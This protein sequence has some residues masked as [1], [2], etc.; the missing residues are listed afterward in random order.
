MHDDYTALFAYNR[1]ADDRVLRSCRRLAPG[2]YTLELGDG[3]RSVRATVVHLAG[4]TDAW[5]RRIRGETVA[6][7]PTEEELPTLDASA[8]LLDEAHDACDR[9]VPE[10]SPG[11]LAATWTYR[12]LQG[13]ARSLPFWAVLRHLVNHGSYHRG[14]I[15]SKLRRLG[16]EPESTDL[17]LWAI[18]SSGR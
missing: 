4:A 1:W 12:N 17:V 16:V 14:Q 15:A 18:E 3:L 2:Q 8:R 13:R 10:L 6:M 7:L 9:L 5:T 11:R